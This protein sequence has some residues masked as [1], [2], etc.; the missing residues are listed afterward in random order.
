LDLSPR[1]QQSLSK[2]F[3]KGNFK[4]EFSEKYIE[5]ISDDHITPKWISEIKEM[6]Q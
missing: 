2:I 6:I 1:K 5:S 3:K 4:F